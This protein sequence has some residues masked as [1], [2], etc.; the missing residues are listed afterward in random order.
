MIDAITRE[1]ITIRTTG[2]LGHAYF[3][4]PEDQLGTVTEALQE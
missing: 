2:G 4:L 3:M 1:R